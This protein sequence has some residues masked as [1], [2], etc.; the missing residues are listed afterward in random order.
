M[1]F[2]FRTSDGQYVI[3]DTV[4]QAINPNDPSAGREVVAASIS[5]A[6]L[7]NFAKDEFLSICG[8]IVD[9]LTQT[10]PAPS[11]SRDWFKDEWLPATVYKTAK[12]K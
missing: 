12:E 6:Q 3:F 8:D 9:Q 1:Q 2:Q 4:I 7:S 11:E 5:D 10:A